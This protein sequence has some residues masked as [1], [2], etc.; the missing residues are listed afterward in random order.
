MN[1]KTTR[2]FKEARPLFWP[3]CLV[4]L[5][6]A[7]PLVHRA[8]W[9]EGVTLMGFL[10]GVPLL[11]ALP[12]GNEFQHRTLA[13][14]LTEPVERMEIW[15][16]KFGVTVVAILSADLVFYFGW[17]VGAVQLDPIFPPSLL[18][19]F[20]VIA[21]IASA[22]FWTLF[23]R[24]TIGSV[25]LNMGVHA[26]MLV[27]WA[28]LLASREGTNYHS[29]A[30]KTFGVSAGFVI[31]FYAGIMLWLGRRKLARFQVTGA[32]GG[33]DLLIAGPNVMP[34]ALADWFR[35][36]PTGPVLNLIRKELHLLRPL[37]L[38]TLL[39]VVG[40]SCLTLLKLVPEPG[41]A[42]NFS[43]AVTPV[44]AMGVISTLMLAIL[45]GSLSLGEEK[46]SG[47][48]AWQLTMPVSARL[49]W[50]VKLLMA[51]CAGVVCAV[52]LPVLVLNAGGFRFGTPFVWTQ[53][54][55]N[56]YTPVDMHAATVWMLYVL[57]LSFASFWC[58]CAFNGTVRAVLWVFPLQGA[59][60]MAGQ[61][62][63]WVAPGLMDLVLSRFDIFTNFHFTNAVS[64][65]LI[66]GLAEN[67]MLSVAVILVPIVI[68][69]LIQSYRLFRAQPQDNL[70]SVIRKMLPLATVA[71]LCIFCLQA[72]YALANHARRQM[73][74]MFH[75]TQEAIVKIQSGTTNLDA[76]HPLQLTEEDLAK[77]APLSDRTRRWLRNSRISVGPNKSSQILFVHS[78][79]IENWIPFPSEKN[80]TG[81]TATIDL[82]GGSECTV[83]FSVGLTHE[84]G[85]L[86]G[87][88][89]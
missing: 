54:T 39:A 75:E 14:L 74:M 36:R 67:F 28:N 45:A 82:A 41:S 7:L 26:F 51:L 65:I 21:I 9:N 15:A 78:I 10:L 57:L 72:T 38:L 76:A 18:A 16:E 53:H 52:L 27:G 64:N 12:F 55:S 43:S 24:S 3:W 32:M 50:L 88:C 61:F 4:T 2:L 89:K 37:W 69:A 49:Q 48:L 8:D 59:L 80:Y 81:F 47:T 66:F 19:G 71:F 85:Y 35:C 73:W 60:V 77:A 62:G 42:K 5:V 6:G 11:A 83:L 20:W 40:W 22:T 17:R 23:T 29:P 33:D 56:V 63:A 68:V 70:S 79:F 58:A 87:V 34:K 84:M 31:L 44:I 1:A 86:A 25:A 13:I 46:S 30:P